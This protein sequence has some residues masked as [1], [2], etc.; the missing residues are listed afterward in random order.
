[1]ESSVAKTAHYKGIGPPYQAKR[2]SYKSP[3]SAKDIVRLPAT[4]K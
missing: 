4:M 2:R 3:R 1:M